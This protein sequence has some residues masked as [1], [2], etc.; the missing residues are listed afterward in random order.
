M[1]ENLTIPGTDYFH[2]SQP[3]LIALSPAAQGSA[4]R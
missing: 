3:F 4:V 1:C 2:T